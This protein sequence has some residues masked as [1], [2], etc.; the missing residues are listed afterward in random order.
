M[1]K[2]SMAH[3]TVAPIESAALSPAKS[4]KSSFRL[5]IQALRAVA[6]AGVVLYH[7]W[8]HRLP[9][10]FVGVD[11]FFVISGFLITS[12]LVNKP[13]KKLTDVFDFWAR[14]IKRLL[15]ASLL[16]LTFTAIASYF[17][18][19]V[20]AWQDTGKQIISSAL[21]VQNWVLASDSVDYLASENAPTA[22]QHFWSLSVEEQFYF[23][24]PIVIGLL[25]A[26]GVKYR[27]RVFHILLVGIGTVTLVSLVVSIWLSIHDSAS[28]YFVTPTRIWELAAGGA[29]AI[30]FNRPSAHTGAFS[31]VLS[32]VGCIGIFTSFLIINGDMA[33]PSYIAL[34]PV[35]STCLVIGAHSQS[36]HSPYMLMR[37]GPAQ[38]IGNT[39]YSIYLWHWPLLVILPTVFGTLRWWHK[40]G[41]IAA[42]LIISALSM[43]WVEN[44]FKRSAFFSTSIRT[45]M[46]AVLMM[47]IAATS[48]F[49]LQYAAHAK[50]RASMSA[51]E[52][53]FSDNSPCLGARSTTTNASDPG[54][55]PEPSKL[56]LDPASAKADKPDAYADGCW[57]RAPFTGTR[58]IC[59]YGKGDKRIALVGNSHVG[60]WLPALQELAEKN[61][62]QIDTY[63][64]DTC[65]PTDAII[66]LKTEEEAQGCHAYGQWAKKKT[67]SGNYDAII[68]SNRQVS[69]IQGFD[70]ENTIPAAA[71]GYEQY[72]RDWN[73]SDTPVIVLRDT[74]FPSRAGVN[75]P[76]CIA[77]KG[78]SSCSGTT[79]TWH[80]I[81][82]MARAASDLDFETQTVINP[83]NQLCPRGN[84]PGTVGGV[85]VYFDG[86]HMTATYSKTLAPW[87]E[88]QLRKQNAAD[89]IK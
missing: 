88:N 26:L 32:W 28:A 4:S 9:G 17:F 44:R 66:K 36:R 57:A 21:Y 77:K 75:V 20:S 31:A 25:V 45:F 69:P 54:T 73:A 79:K 12:H 8:P 7:L 81:D 51:L 35:V 82:P 19:A 85:I 71:E 52:R 22:V 50:E 47:A 13:P 62:W 83:T 6:V 29:V 15:P 42:V 76:D 58:P 10:G 65:N 72:L 86:S 23:V 49:G 67:T 38:F 2:Y 48:G 70:L 60:H 61:D 89:I 46:T 63:L 16:V 80:S 11:V 14:R 34:L 56:L 33:F 59:H 64:V 41:L 5:D 43:K 53:A 24:W 55:C 30:L 1:S 18:G 87:L 3:A 27:L 37:I 74:P 84:C 68:T 78:A 39:S 40:F